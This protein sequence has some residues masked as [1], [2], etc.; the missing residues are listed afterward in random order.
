MDDVLVADVRADLTPADMVE[1]TLASSLNGA[2]LGVSP[3]RLR[4]NG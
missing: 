4:H 2:P 1:R 3:G